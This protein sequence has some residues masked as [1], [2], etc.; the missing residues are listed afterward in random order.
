[1]LP[2]GADAP[3]TYDSDELTNYE[4]GLRTGNASG[5]FS[6]D[7]AA[8]F[9]DWEDIQLYQV[10]NDFGINANGGTAESQGFEFTATARTEDGLSFS[11]TGAYTD[12]EL[13]EDTDPDRRR[14]RRRRVAIRAGVDARRRRRLR[15]E[16]VRR[17]HGLCRR[18]GFLHGRAAGRLQRSRGPCRS[19]FARCSSWTATRPSTC[20]RG[21]LQDHWSLELYVKNL[22][23]VDGIT[24]YAAPGT[25]PN[26]AAGI[27]VIRPRTVGMSL[28]VRF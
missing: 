24:D 5:S 26:G 25:L 3:S 28:G 8:F 13:T 18:P 2:P 11:L 1:M 6:L 16:R 14:L 27:S 15:V 9:L 10:V 4:V 21:L 19:Y 17:R 7:V 23:D 12:A 22:G 20:V